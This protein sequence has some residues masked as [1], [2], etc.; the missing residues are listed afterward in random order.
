MKS[1]HF[2]EKMNYALK[3]N[4]LDNTIDPLTATYWL[5]KKRK[6]KN[7]CKG[8][9][10]VSEGQTIIKVIFLKKITIIK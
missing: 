8:E 7:I 3:I 4:Q 1:F 2:L 9:K 10:L 6:I 5:L